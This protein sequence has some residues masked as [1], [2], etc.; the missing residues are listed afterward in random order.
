MP[1][2]SEGHF[3]S[4]GVQGTGVP[5]EGAEAPVP[6]LCPCRRPKVS[7]VLAVPE[8]VAAAEGDAAAY[9]SVGAGD[10][11]PTVPGGAPA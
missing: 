7:V 3:D 10:G 4:E 9:Q 1:V 8:A 5:A 2:L 6:L 11:Q